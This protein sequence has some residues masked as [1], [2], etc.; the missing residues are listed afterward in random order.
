[1]IEEPVITN[2]PSEKAMRDK[3]RTCVY[4]YCRHHSLVA[5][6]ALDEIDAHA[7]RIL[8]TTDW[9]RSLKAFIMVL[10]GNEM[11][12]S[13]VAGTPF[14]RRILLLPQCMKSSTGC[15]AEMDALGL[16]CVECGKCSIGE[17]QRD[18]EK[19]GYQ[20]V[21]AEGSTI[22]AALLAN[23]EADAVVGVSCLQALEKSFR[24]L[25]AHAVPG[26]GVPLLKNGCADTTVDMEWI[27]EVLAMRDDA[28][29]NRRL[30]LTALR[31]EVDSWF[32]PAY[33]ASILCLS[34]SVTEQIAIE[35][36]LKGGKRWRP[37]LAAGVSRVLRDGNSSDLGAIKRLAVAVECFHKASLVH[38]DIEDEEEQR[39][40]EPALHKKYGLAVALNVGD[41]LIGE[42]YRLIAGTG[43]TAD[44]IRAMLEVASRGHRTLCVGQG[45]EL[46]LRKTPASLSLAAVLDIFRRK[47][48]PAFDV[49]LQLGAVAAGCDFETR[50]L[51]SRFSDAMGVAYQIRDDLADHGRDGVLPPS[52]ES[53]TSIIAAIRCGTGQGADLGEADASG[54]QEPIR[55]A[56]ERKARDLLTQFEHEALL[57]LRPLRHSGLKCFLQRLT[58]LILHPV[59]N[60]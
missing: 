58:T 1:M 32:E 57:A 35:W 4:E 49:A 45:E 6:L 44:Q 23:G 51:L 54:L 60:G 22:V 47:T 36:L 16:L 39:Y 56:A 34:G 5:P 19:L 26:I 55:E 33:L 40:G 42:G 31:Q 38:D 3:I 59:S 50:N 53:R 27:R 11:W 14:D 8:E 29:P 17:I 48:A 41:L 25:M 12:R 13:T 43:V 37:L 18:A 20:V 46:L 7:R 9:D 2:A 10:V 28:R 30:N 52:G 15:R 21:V 24:P